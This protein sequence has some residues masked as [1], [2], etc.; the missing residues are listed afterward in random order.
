MAMMKSLLLL[1]CAAL[2]NASPITIPLTENGNLSDILPD[3]YDFKR[4]KAYHELTP[5]TDVHASA[6]R[7][8]DHDSAVQFRLRWA[9]TVASPIFSSPVLFPSG[10]EGAKQIFLASFYRYAELVEADGYKP[11]GWPLSFEDAAF[12]GSPMLHDVDGD[13]HIDMGMVDRDGN[14]YWVRIGQ[15]GEYLEDYHVQ[16]PRLKVKRDWA[17]GLDPKFVDS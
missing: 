9:T 16:V 13:G 12:Q 3:F 5:R 15:A 14:L 8:G 2:L 7:H 17:Q 6:V 1:V 4:G 10:P 11:W